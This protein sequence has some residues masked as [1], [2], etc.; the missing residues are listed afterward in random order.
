MNYR[1]D[2]SNVHSI[3]EFA[4]EIKGAAMECYRVLKPDCFSAILIR[5]TRRSMHNQSSNTVS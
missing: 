5:D 2:L 3:L 1:G 4:K